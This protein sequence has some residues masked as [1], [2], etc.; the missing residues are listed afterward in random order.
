[1]IDLR[2]RAV[3]MALRQGVLLIVGAIERYLGV[4]PSPRRNDP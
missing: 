1:M 2:T 3:W 4:E